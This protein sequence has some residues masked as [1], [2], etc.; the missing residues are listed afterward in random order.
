ME[1]I[2]GILRK[3]WGYDSFRPMQREIIKSVLTGHD[4]LGLMPTG[5]GKSVTFQVPGIALG[6]LT[7]VVT[8][9]I[10]LMKDQVD[11]LKARGIKAAF[12]HSG[13]PYSETSRV[14]QSLLHGNCR[15]LYVSPER[16]ASDRFCEEL[17]ALKRVSLVV[18]DEAHC[19]S[20]WGYDFRPSYLN[21]SKL[22]R[23]LP[24]VPF[25]AVTASATDEVARDIMRVLEFRNPRRFATS[26]ARPNIS[27]VVRDTS[28]KRERM[29]HILS[30]VE[31]T[32]IVY[33]RSRSRTVEL[34]RYLTEAGISAAPFHAKLDYEVKAE[35]I[36]AWKEGSLRVMVATNAFG[37]G[38]DKPDVR[39][40]I[41]Y[42]SPPSM[43]DYYQEA[44]RAGR[45][46]KPSYAVLLVD[47]F[48]SRR[49]RLRLANSFPT[50]DV[51]ERV[52]EYVCVFLGI[53]VGS[54]YDKLYEFDIDKFLVT[55]G[56]QHQQVAGALSILGGAG[57]MEYVDETENASR[58]MILCT[59]EE[60]YDL[61]YAGQF[62]DAVLRSLLRNCPGLF[63]DY[64]FFTETRIARDAGCR[65]DDV[66][67]TLLALSR[68]GV[69]SYVPRRRTP[70]I[71]MPTAREDSPEWLEIPPAVYQERRERMKARIESMIAY[72]GNSDRCRPGMILEYFGEKKPADCGSCDVCRRKRR[73]HDRQTTRELENNFMTNLRN[74]PQGIDINYIKRH[75]G[76]HAPEVIA[77]A[78]R[79]ADEGIAEMRDGRYILK[80]F[81][82][83]KK[84]PYV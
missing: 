83:K 39:V 80:E 72:S 55:F 54:G 37:M 73:P 61:P 47:G 29:A 6:G 36:N 23:V 53:E 66:Y 70:Y 62:S 25:M 34:A 64:V 71:Y 32:A 13:M 60:L 82:C 68:L 33:V 5:G 76:A 15:F 9:L 38:I 43:E 42:D 20:Q 11:N 35:R 27:Y 75:Y 12:L 1:D 77:Y 50:R 24:P 56:M 59:K 22:R 81:I 14:W 44:G 49:L 19:I 28:D 48:D 41:H 78:A 10:A 45:D 51:I 57:Y 16:L 4:T 8:P 26:F 65:P 63:S 84:Y 7:L 74:N 79:I 46:G 18:V 30:S 21:I 58:A 3:Y 40:V 69:L 17:R 31:G 52:Y 67:D 2:H